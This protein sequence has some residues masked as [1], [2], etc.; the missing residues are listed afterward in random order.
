MAKPRTPK[1]RLQGS[2]LRE[3]RHKV[4]QLKKVGGVSK[5]VNAAKQRPTRYM[6]SKV[7][8]LEPVLRGEAVLIPRRKIRPDLLADYLRTSK[9]FNRRVML[10]KRTDEKLT[11]RRGLPEFERLIADTGE[12]KVT[13]RRIPLPVSIENLDEF[14][15][16]LRNNPDKWVRR[17]G[18][19]PPWTF[20]FKI[21]GGQS[22]S[23]FEDPELLA[24]DLERYLT[25]AGEDHQEEMW[26]SFELYS[27]H[28]SYPWRVKS[29]RHGKRSK[30]KRRPLAGYK[31][32]E[33]ML[34]QRRRRAAMPESKRELE[35]QK[36]RERI[37]T[38]RENDRYRAR[39]RKKDKVAK[40]LFRREMGI[41]PKPKARGRKE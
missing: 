32:V 41:G 24:D 16:D 15:D 17:R 27:V 6:I 38:L 25:A 28:Q 40:T 20:G 8:S 23:L 5:R 4:S 36:N 31:A 10:S 30:G 14:I 9:S 12:R 18:D 35:R 11:L 21:W 26:E 22:N 13:T 37:A 19:Y 1:Q 29:E 34:R 2:Q 7:K 3:F 33:D 39:E